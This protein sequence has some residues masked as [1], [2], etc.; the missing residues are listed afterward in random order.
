MQEAKGQKETRQI[1][2]PPG[3]VDHVRDWL[4]DDGVSFFRRVK[5]HK[6]KV[7]CTLTSHEHMAL[8]RGEEPSEMKRDRLRAPHPIHFREGTA[9]RNA[10]RNSDFTEG[11]SD[12]DYDGAWEKVVEQAIGECTKCWGDQFLQPCD[13][14]GAGVE[15]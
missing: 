8:R 6:G 10:M 15:K 9:V 4:G 3:L 1:E 11:W 2:I 13:T 5:L 12:H 7:N 14:C